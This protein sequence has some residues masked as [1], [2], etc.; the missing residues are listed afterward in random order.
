[1]VLSNRRKAVVSVTVLFCIVSFSIAATEKPLFDYHQSTL[2]NGLNV[3]TLEDFSCPI[4]AIQVWYQVGSK[5]ERPDRQGYA[6]MFEHMMFKGT[7]HVGPK[8]HFDLIHRTG[9]NSNAHTGFDQ[10]VYEQTLPA[11]QLELALW[12]E[13]ERMAFL[14][15]DQE[16]F[17]TE[18]KV[19]EEELRM[20][21]NEPYGNLDKKLAAVVFKE[22]PYRWMPIGSLS[23]LRATSVADLRA[24][25]QT[26]YIPDNATLIAVG[27]AKHNDVVKLAEKYFGWIQK[28]PLPPRITV[29]EP[30]PDK[31]TRTIIDN[32]NAPA[33]MAGFIFRGVPLGHKDAPALD[34]L[35][36][37]LGG[38]NSSRLY[39]DLVAEHQLAVQTIA[40][41][42]NLQ[43]DGVFIIGALF[44]QGSDPNSVLDKIK[45]HIETI[46]KQPVTREELE[47][48]RNQQLRSIV[49]SNL[50]VESK[51]SVLGSAAVTVGDLSYANKIL[52]QIRDVTA[53]DIQRVAGDYL[54]LDRAFEIVV[55]ENPGG[56]KNATKD[57]ESAAVL[58]QPEKQ[59]PPPGRPGEKRP[60]TFP[61]K[62]P[63]AK[64]QAPD[65]QL[66]Y[67]EQTLKNGL[68]VAV[69][70]NHEVP[71]V[72][73]KL[74]I[75]L[76]ATTESRPGTVNLAAQMLNRGTKTRTEKDLAD[77]MARFAID[78]NGA[79]SMDD[80]QVNANCLVDHLDKA[81]EL[82]SD[83]VINPVFDPN[84]FEKLRKQTLTGL[85]V[86]EQ[87]PEYLAEREFARQLYGQ[88]PYART[89]EGT[90]RDIGR[91]SAQDLNNWWKQH[92]GPKGATL[93]FSGDIELDKAVT[94]AEKYFGGWKNDAVI[95]D[96][97]LPDFPAE[98][99]MRIVLVDYPGS[100]QVQIR[101]GCRSM[102]RKEQP[103]YFA[104]RV[105]NNYFGTSFNSWINETLRVQKG[106]TYG[107]YAY[108]TAQRQSG[109]F[110]INT[111][112]KNE[113]AAQTVQCIL[114][115]LGRLRKEPPSARELDDSKCYISGSFIQRQETPQQ[116]AGDLWLL[117]SENLSEDYYKNLVETVQNTSAQECVKLAQKFLN[118]DK[119]V[120]VVVGDASVIRANLE[121]IAP[122]SVVSAN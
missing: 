64:M 81:M 95:P 72:S 89:V 86:Q 85:A 55:K 44:A 57:D 69:V 112:T 80:T 38:T 53:S 122:V 54:R 77:Q 79:A 23:H 1:M 17:D 67:T 83:V 66:N 78:I 21:E 47:T 59:A 75:A 60:E 5:D 56:M 107:A 14:K 58:A 35:A 28:R 118:P 33:P 34:F 90:T 106:L 22:H 37:I 10:T 93:I 15:I 98:P 42:W 40:T 49:T 51:A 119:L 31:P 8:D 88:H 117:K 63:Q 110:E 70:P 109:Y 32:E 108:F 2:D 82:M 46:Q 74:G 68:K 91:L 36:S 120:F 104:A 94:L 65:I 39:R 116:T 76:G 11:D 18:R 12:L 99:K 7:D 111:F 71:F 121:K 52:S 97:K 13:A 50:E 101:A 43:Q 45:S 87:N 6:H 92:I 114:D 73:V 4:V 16:A 48:A 61:A 103:E 26:Y 25:W 62:A 113:T 102:N 100:A 20:R 41:S 24:F 19:V 29:R 105:V 30:M 84:E 115:L 27:A 9:G 3:V 96:T